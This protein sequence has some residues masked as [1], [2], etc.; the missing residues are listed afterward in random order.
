[1]RLEESHHL[2]EAARGDRLEAL[3]VLA[4]N[5]SMRQG[6]LVALKWDDVDL[7]DSLLRVRRTLTHAD[8]TSII[9]EPKTKNSR[10][11]IGL[12][13]S[14]VTI[15]QHPP[16][17]LLPPLARHAGGYRPRSRRNPVVNRDRFALLH[18]CCTKALEFIQGLD[19]FI[20]FYLQTTAF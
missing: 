7:E 17:H 15:Y 12:T 19:L 8:T 14:A 3:Y 5:T 10:R 1:L 20:K 18:G 4:L 11:T 13:M 2:L 16:R 6:E 9:G